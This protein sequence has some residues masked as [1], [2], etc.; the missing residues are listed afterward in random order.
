MSRLNM[1]VIKNATILQEKL[2]IIVFSHGFA[3]HRNSYTCLIN[4][5]VSQGYIVFSLEHYETMEVPGYWKEK[6][7]TKR[8]DI[9]KKYK[10]NNVE[11]RFQ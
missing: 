3:A 8:F 7:Q 4:E 9:S 11:D 6:N 10:R 5:L 1:N 2:N